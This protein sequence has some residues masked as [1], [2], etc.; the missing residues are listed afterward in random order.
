[1]LSARELIGSL[2]ART[3]LRISISIAPPQNEQKRLSRMIIPNGVVRRIAANERS[4][5]QNWHVI[6]LDPARAK[7]IVGDS[8]A[9]YKKSCRALQDV[10]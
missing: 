4:V 5:R 10:S 2:E 8:N 7:P 9:R 1:M 3:A 6:R